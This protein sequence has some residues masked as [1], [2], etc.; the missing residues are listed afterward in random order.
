MTEEKTNPTPETAAT[1]T[2]APEKPEAKKTEQADRGGRGRGGSSRGKG[3][4]RGGNRRKRE[5]KEFEESILRIDRVTRVTRGGRQ[6]RFRVTVVIG[7]RKGRVG[8]GIGKSEEI[9]GSIQKAVSMAKKNLINVPTFNETI[10]HP[11]KAKFK[12]SYIHLMPAQKG[13]G[14]IA[15]GAVRKILDL[16]GVKNVLSKIHGSRN[17]I[18]CAYCTFAALRSLANQAPHGSEAEIKKEIETTEKTEEVK[19]AKAIIKAKK[20]E[21]KKA[22]ESKKPAKK[23]EKA[24]KKEVKEEKET[25]KPAKA[26]KKEP[27]KKE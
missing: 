8:F 12:A 15:G 13:K 27:K 10:P 20:A 18:T 3:R 2:A 22:E 23:A 11:V 5:P 6:M 17:K 26:A 24:D 4:G 9:V 25:K 14:V 19:D 21:N 1:A 7:D 16:A